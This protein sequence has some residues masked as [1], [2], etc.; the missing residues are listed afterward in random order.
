MDRDDVV[1]WSKCKI[2]HLYKLTSATWI[3]ISKRAV[4]TNW[5]WSYDWTNERIQNNPRSL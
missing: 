3:D 1:H 2:H 4:D 5:S